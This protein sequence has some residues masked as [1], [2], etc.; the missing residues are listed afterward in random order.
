MTISAQENSS[1][2]RCY[3]LWAPNPCKENH[4]LPAH[5]LCASSA[6][7]LNIDGRLV[8]LQQECAEYAA[9]SERQSSTDNAEASVKYAAHICAQ[10]ARTLS[11]NAVCSATCVQLRFA[12]Q[13]K[14]PCNLNVCFG[15]SEVSRVQMSSE[16]VQAECVP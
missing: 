4:R 14:L 16:V 10:T 13:G 12:S 8:Q 2:K 3:R 15:V 1:R 6:V 11:R 5:L 9:A 7:A